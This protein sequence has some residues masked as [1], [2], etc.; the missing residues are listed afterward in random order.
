[1]DFEFYESL[2]EEEAQLYLENYLRVEKEKTEQMF[3]MLN[4]DGIITDYS[5]ESIIPVFEWILDKLTTV[6]IKLDDSIPDWVKNGKNSA[7]DFDD[8]SKIYILRASYYLGECFVRHS[9]KLK[10][11]SGNRDNFEQNMPVVT[12]F[13]HGI[14]MATMMV[15]QN[16]IHRIMANRGNIKD[17]EMAINHWLSDIP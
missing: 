1:M 6:K 13:K 5:I 12:G 3:A 14:E 8:K 15:A 10:W 11:A 4:S 2:T 9:H 17:I 16:L 7:L